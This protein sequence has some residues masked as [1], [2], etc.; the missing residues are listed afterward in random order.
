[1]AGGAPSVW[2]AVSVTVL[3]LLASSGGVKMRLDNALAIS[4]DC[5]ILYQPFV[6]FQP[7]FQM[8]YLAAFSLVFSSGILS[9]SKDC[10]SEY[11]FLSHQLVN[12]LFIRYYS[13]IFMNYLFIIF[14]Q[15]RLRSSLFSYH[16][17]SKYCFTCCDMD[18][19]PKS[20]NY[21]SLFMSHFGNWSE[22]ITSWLSSL[23]YQL[24]TPGK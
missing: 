12:F 5:F 16:I 11:L 14:C 2:R 8:S 19:F 22:S 4:A 21:C 9:K 23:P 15:S 1:M 24:W 3:V 20:L 7:G 10:L 6:L 13:F 17:T 18:L